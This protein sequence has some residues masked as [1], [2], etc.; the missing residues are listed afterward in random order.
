MEAELAKGPVAHGW[1]DQRWTLSRVN[2]VIGRRFH[3]SYIL[4]GVRKLP[5]RHG[6][7]LPDPDKTCCRTRRGPGHRLGEGDLAADGSTAAALDAW[8][9]FEDESGF[10]MSRPSPAAGPAADRHPSSGS[11]DAPAAGS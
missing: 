8:I 10:S 9:V 1:A 6:F 11:A 5:I 2:T 7:F 3:K 4:Q